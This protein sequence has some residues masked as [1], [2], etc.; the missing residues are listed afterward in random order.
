M[1]PIV[2]F[3]DKDL[4]GNLADIVDCISPSEHPPADRQRLPLSLWLTI[5]APLAAGETHIPG[6]AWTT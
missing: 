1:L 6:T 4:E 5:I 2:F 3:I